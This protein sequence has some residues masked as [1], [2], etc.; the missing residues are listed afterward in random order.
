ALLA[1]LSAKTDNCRLPATRATRT[2]KDSSE[3]RLRRGAAD[4]GPRRL[5]YLHSDQSRRHEAACR[6][7]G[8]TGAG[9]LREN[10]HDPAHCAD[11][12]GPARGGPTRRLLDGDGDCLHLPRLF[13]GGGARGESRGRR[14]LGVAEVMDF[15]EDLPSSA[16]AEI[17][18][19]TPATTHQA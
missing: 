9:A 18:K 11:R 17:P 12:A 6:R 1:I 5:G 14:T 3:L 2:G 10:E 19:A 4:P 16:L 8:R 7:G 13:R 15:S